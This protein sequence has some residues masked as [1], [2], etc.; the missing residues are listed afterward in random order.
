MS[1]RK[2]NRQMNAACTYYKNNTLS[3]EADSKKTKRAETTTNKRLLIYTTA[4]I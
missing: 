1:N 4:F 3:K 2:L